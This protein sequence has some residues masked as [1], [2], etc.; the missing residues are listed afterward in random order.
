MGSRRA[1]M[2]PCARHTCTTFVVIQEIASVEMR[3][4]KRLSHGRIPFSGRPNAARTCPGGM[5]MPSSDELLRVITDASQMFI[6]YVDREERYRFVN[7]TYKQHFGGGADEIIGM[8]VSEV[9]V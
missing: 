3:A 6:A 1:E 7:N 4:R 9:L 5:P 8:R 2:D